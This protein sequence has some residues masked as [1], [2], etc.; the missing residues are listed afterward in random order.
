MRRVQEATTTV[1]INRMRRGGFQLSIPNASV[2]TN[3]IFYKEDVYQFENF[4]NPKQFAEFYQAV[5]DAEEYGKGS[6]EIRGIA[7]NELAIDIV[8]V[9]ENKEEKENE[10]M[11]KVEEEVKEE[12]YK[13]TIEED[14]RIPGTDIIL[15]KG[16]EVMI[17]PAKVEEAEQSL[18][19]VMKKV[20]KGEKLDK[21]ESKILK[22]ALNAAKGKD[23]KDDIVDKIMAKVGKGEDLS[24]AE[25]K[26]LS[27]A[28]DAEKGKKD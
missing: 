22:A 11:R 13:L 5:E 7:P 18:D 23:D 17:Y 1:V 28:Q 19:K 6:F 14:V 10:S 12:G 26:I 25:K 3:K 15:E 20:S 16:E 21:E 4:F 8:R 9:L 24:P 27:A 2:V